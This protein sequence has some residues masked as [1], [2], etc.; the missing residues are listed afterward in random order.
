MIEFKLDPDQEFDFTGSLQLVTTC[1][2][3]VDLNS[4]LNASMPGADLVHVGDVRLQ[5]RKLLLWA[6]ELRRANHELHGFHLALDA[7]HCC[8]HNTENNACPPDHPSHILCH[9]NMAHVELLHEITRT[10]FVNSR[11][12]F[13]QSATAGIPTEILTHGKTHNYVVCGDWGIYR[14]PKLPPTTP[15][16]GTGRETIYIFS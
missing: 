15:H 11:T 7:K 1:L 5:D 14:C 4:A 9:R 2:E 6:Q 12:K 16:S 13:C 3:T 10:A 8:M